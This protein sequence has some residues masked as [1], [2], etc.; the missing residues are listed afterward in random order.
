MAVDASV[1]SL[2]LYAGSTHA[3]ATTRAPLRGPILV[4]NASTMPSSAARSTRPLSTK[5][6]FERLDS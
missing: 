5:Q 2:F 6:R 4:S 1:N 3:R